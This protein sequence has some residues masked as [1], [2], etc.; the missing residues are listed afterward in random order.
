MP[1]RIARPL[2]DVVSV[3]SLLEVV[4]GGKFVT[5]VNLPNEPEFKRCRETVQ[6]DVLVNLVGYLLPQ[7]LEAK[8]EIP[9]L[10]SRSRQD[11]RQPYA[12]G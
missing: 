5:L 8:L 3:R 2:V 10:L 6:H 11:L 7:H 4:D 12:S 1:R 9:H